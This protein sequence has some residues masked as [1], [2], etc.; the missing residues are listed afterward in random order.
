MQGDYGNVFLKIS[1]VNNKLAVADYF[2]MYNTVAESDADQDLGSGGALLV[3]PL[4][5]ASGTFWNLAIG[6]GKDDNIY[7]VDRSNMGTAMTR[8]LS[9]AVAGRN[10]RCWT[11]VAG[12]T[13]TAKASPTNAGRQLGGRTSTF[14]WASI[15]RIPTLIRI[16]ACGLPHSCYLFQE[17][18]G[19][20]AEPFQ[21]KGV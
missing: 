9:H 5:D 18:S 3:P 16:P 4:K 19:G 8:R 11:S 12:S 20:S 17:G 6:G 2:A 21:T 15:W 14:P 13:V 10:L 7:I 1:T